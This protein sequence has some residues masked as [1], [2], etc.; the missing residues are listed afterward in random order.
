MSESDTS[1]LVSFQDNVLKE[2][3][4]LQN[5]VIWNSCILRRI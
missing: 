2:I 3:K 4:M 5:M 1:N